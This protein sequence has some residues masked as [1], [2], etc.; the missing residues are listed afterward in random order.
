MAMAFAMAGTEWEWKTFQDDTGSVYNG[1]SIKGAQIPHGWGTMDFKND[2]QLRL[3]Y[4]GDFANGIFNGY[5]TLTCLPGRPDNLLKYGGS[6][7]NGLP[8]GYCSAEFSDGSSYQGNW[9]GNG[10]SGHG[11]Q[12]YPLGRTDG[13]MRYRSEERRVGKECRSRW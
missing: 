2:P 8:Q 10:R 11:T 5:G 4:V 1:N 9:S 7:N 3:Q 13:M 6:W 12:K